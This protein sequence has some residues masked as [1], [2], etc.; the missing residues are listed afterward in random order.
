MIRFNIFKLFIFISLLLPGEVFAQVQFTTPGSQNY[1]M[2]DS[3]TVVIVEA[4]GG[5]GGGST[6]TNNNRRG[7]G[8]GG[9][10]Y[11]RSTL[12]V[13]PNTSF[14][15]MVGAGGNASSA[16]GNSTFNGTALVAVGG[17]GG[18]NNSATAGAG[19]TAASSTGDVKYSGGNGADGGGTWSGGGG[20]GAGSTGAGGNAV[21]QTAGAGTS[22]NGGNGG[23]GID[24]NSDGNPGNIYGGG[25]GGARK[26]TGSDKIGGSGAN[27]LVVIT[28][29]TT[30]RV[31]ATTGT[32][33]RYY[34]TLK[35]AFDAI[36][37]GTH[38]GTITVR[39]NGST[40]E[41][42]SAVLNA[43]GDGSANYSSVTVFPTAASLSVS[44]SLATPLI[45]LNGADNVVFDGRVN[46][47]GAVSLTISNT[48]TAS[49][50]RT[51]ELI[52][53][54]QNNTVEYSIIRGAGTSSTQGTIIFSTSTSG[55]GNDGNFIQFNN[56][57]SVSAGSRPLNA[58][59]SAGTATRE[60]SENTIRNNN[61]FDFLNAS[62]ASNG[63]HIASNSTVF[64][65]TGNSFYETTSLAP[66]AAVEY[67]LV[68]INNTSGADFIVSNN[69]FGGNASSASGT[70]TKTNSNNN[71]FSAI[72]LNVGTTSS[73]VQGNTIRNFSY[74]NSGAANWFG[75][76]IQGG[77]VNVG[78]VTG[79]IIGAE[80][81]TGSVSFTAGAT[82]ASFNGIYISGTNNVNVSNNT[83]GSITTN[84]S[85]SANANQ[86]YG[87]FKASGSG[88]ITISNNLIGSLSTDNSV[89][90]ASLATGNSQLLYAIYTLGTSTNTI[91]GNKVSYVTNAT[92]ETTLGSRVRGIFAN[93]G[94]NSITNNLVQFVKTRGLSNGGNYANTA[95]VGISLISTTSGN[96]QEISGNDVH[97]LENNT[98]N[99]TLKFETYGIYYDGPSNVTGIIS[100]NFVR[101]FIVPAGSSTGHFLHGISL[102]GGSYIASN[103][104]VFMGDNID[105]GCS[106]WGMWTNSVNDVKIYHN[107]IYLTGVALSGTS[108]SYALRLL[109]CPNSV[110]IRN[111]I[112]WDGRTNLLGGVSHFAIYL[113][114]L[115]NATVDYNDYQFAQQFGRVGSN[116]YTTL[117][118]WQTGT[119]LDTNSLED[120]PELVNLGGVLPIDY[121]TG[122]QLQGVTIAGQTTDFDGVTR[123]APTMGA[124]EFFPDPVE[125][126]NGNLFRQAYKTLKEAFDAINAGT[127]TGN[128]TII[129]RGNTT[130][131]ASAVLNASG[132]G[133]SNYSRILIYPGRSGIRVTG[134]LAAPVVSL[135]GARN[136]TFDGRVNGTGTPYEFTV[137]N[138][139]TSNTSGN[140]TIRFI[141]N[142]QSDTLRYCVLRGASTATVGGVVYFATSTQ[143]SGNNDNVLFSN[144]ITPVDSDR[145]Q[146]MIYSEGTAAKDNSGNKIE[147]N[148]IFNFLRT[149]VESH[150]I[151]I[152]SNSTAFSILNNSFYQTSSFVPSA[153]VIHRVIYINNTSGNS[154]VVSGNHIGGNSANSAGTWTKTNAQNN[155][156]YAIAVNAGTTTASSVQGNFIR[157][158]SYA[159]SGAANW[160]GIH[161]GAGAVNVGTSA[162]NT[163]GAATGT[164]SVTLTNGATDG[165]AYMIN[166]ASTGT[167][168]VENNIIGSVTTS[169]ANNAHAFNLIGIHKTATAGTTGINKNTIGSTS[170]SDSFRASSG[171]TSNAQVVYGIYSQGTGAIT[172]NENIIANNTNSTS[173]ST[174]GTRGRIN[175]IWISAGSANTVTGNQIYLLSIAN[176]NTADTFEA[177]VIGLNLSGTVAGRTISSN[178]I[179]SLSNSFGTQA[180]HV[181]GLRYEGATA[182]TNTVSRNFIHSLSATSTAALMSGIRIV[183]GS[184]TYSNN[185]VSLGNSTS[186]IIY[187]IYDT[188]SASQTCNVYFNTIYIGGVTAGT[189]NS[190]AFY[191]AASA[192]TRNYRNNIFT[193]ARSRT[194]GS[195]TH[196][197]IYYNATGVANLTVDY[198]D[199]WVSGTGGVLAY[200]SANRTTLADLRTALGS[201]RDVNSLN[202]NPTFVSAG[203]TV[204]ADYKVG[205]SLNGIDG[206]GINIDYGNLSRPGTGPTMGAWE[207]NVN[208]WKGKVDSDD[209][210]TASNWTGNL[211]PAVD[212]SIE[213]DPVPLNHCVMDQ[214]RSV[215]NIINAQGT[216]RVVTNGFKLTIKGSLLFSGGAQIDASDDDSMVE[217]AG[218]AQQNIPSGSFFNDEV[219]NLN[220]NNASDV[221]LSGSLRLL[222]NIT[223]GSG[224]IELAANGTTFTYGGLTAQ[225]IPDA[226][227]KNSQ[228]HNLVIDNAAGVSLNTDITVNNNLTINASKFLVINPERRMT[229]SGTVTNN[230]GTGGLIVKSS[231]TQPNGSFV[232]FNAFGNPVQA[233]VEMYSK[234]T[235]DLS[236]PSL[237]RY[238]WQFFGIPIR[239][240]PAN[241]TFAGSFVRR[242]IESGDSVFNHWVALTN[243]SVLSPFIGYEIVHQNPKT[244]YF[245][246]ELV[247]H[248][249]N[250]GQLPVTAGA[251]YPGQHLFTNPYTAAI[252]IRQIDMGS[253]SDGS[254]YLYNTGTYAAWDTISSASGTAP[255]QYVVIPK[256]LAGLGGLPRQV[257]SMSSM[258]FRFSSNSANDYV[259]INY[260][261]V[262]MKNS[263]MQRVKGVT[264]PVVEDLVQTLIEVWSDKG[265][266]Q[267]W[268]FSNEKFSENYDWGYDGLKVVVRSLSPVI[269]AI[270]KDHAYQVNAVKDINNMPIAFQAGQDTLYTMVFYH[271]NTDSQY[272]KIFLHDMVENKMVDMTEDGSKYDFRAVPGSQAQQRFRIITQPTGNVVN[273]ET[274]LQIFTADKTI[275]VRN[276]GDQEGEMIAY[277]L[278]GRI[279]GRTR[280]FANG[281]TALAVPNQS[282][283][284]VKVVTPD[285]TLTQSLII[286]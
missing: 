286:Q 68:R 115:T 184:T 176:A 239:T 105:V 194:G 280:V 260:N 281:L 164:G 88:N 246:G 72:N 206:T 101:T 49:G 64:S 235:F 192:N 106:L 117:E 9:G 35:G 34:T 247:N 26:T 207:R 213:F 55:A 95:L 211:V 116:D 273:E 11:A 3:V 268:L 37:A 146:Q 228:M 113:N 187:G 79:N 69:F 253:G 4:W 161:I 233:T 141:N 263:E 212:A 97:D 17:S 208:R 121:Q 277:D 21:N 182:G 44:G 127:W 229:V 204:A 147:S 24:T 61:I 50:A 143:S 221:V 102:F 210:N 124:W 142:A 214:N 282:V 89:Q 145:P 168:T 215:T 52:N 255:G 223:S 122:V 62:N 158:F 163:I 57:T 160:Y 76:N 47:A 267:L 232:F 165:F 119:S 63:I 285:Q 152:G 139:N 205:I 144:Q 188:G 238:N 60:N 1:T 93:A 193:N 199:Y 236:K 200:Y 230:A 272:T 78:T 237:Q 186:N 74:S 27:G 30:V 22:I 46:R 80:T 270:G 137:T 134:N 7:G 203:S 20:G 244:L 81:G 75:I 157:N 110:D 279:I 6:I 166:I 112:L 275:L 190:F 250:S 249:F 153:S 170:A 90:T 104:I 65:I 148:S 25:G 77:V 251:L 82:G 36:N 256:N 29:I 202:F 259:N 39:I 13:T 140:S 40:T 111:N 109:S 53:S 196:F 231:S 179:H 224:R 216:Y 198:N 154:F 261:D 41:T 155:E 284:V 43:S 130:E 248:N 84:T 245:A 254:V 126:W 266:D 234:A 87:I 120:D 271:Q 265:M 70:W 276:T 174:T 71:T 114:C 252:D 175:G 167:V 180:Y 118:D 201:P 92:S 159:N 15:I 83:I 177:G 125:V 274:K 67:A 172:I 100:R 269:Y 156:F 107:T 131:T 151:H 5:G 169:T 181:M 171:S 86:F 33:L 150:G 96:A 219:Y 209:W 185:I 218:T 12:G 28:P 38:T 241:P 132:S 123:V 195:G 191:S 257:P 135:N 173:N 66:S 240:V 85:S 18:T 32:L 262:V 10:A 243:D 48:S 138:T 42:A 14:T 51:I 73:S 149:G 128:L 242:K 54:A 197:A 133:S 162:G 183:S 129:F 220:I 178:I 2:P 94:A 91:T 258:L 136:V 227:F 226:V 99:T 31:N 56:I 225:S 108:N 45:Q 189:A 264:V 278:S 103:N 19:G 8:G 222:N 283:C 217:F 98:T 59:Y 16:G 58:I 23:S